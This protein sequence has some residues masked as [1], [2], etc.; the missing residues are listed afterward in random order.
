MAG[1]WREGADLL[2]LFVPGPLTGAVAVPTT[3]YLGLALLLL[4]GLGAF[5]LGRAGGRPAPWLLGAAA[6]AAL[7]LGPFLVVAGQTTGWPTPAGLLE[8]LPVLDRV[9]RWYRAG[10]VA[11]LLLAP[12][13]AWASPHRAA[14]WALAALVLVDGRLL[15]PLPARLPVTLLQ[16]DN[17]LVGLSGP[18]AELPPQQ[19]LGRAGRTADLNLLLQLAHG[20]PT[21]GTLD[22]LPGAATGPGLRD[23]QR[24]LRLPVSPQGASL[25]AGGASQL[26]RDGYRWLA[27]YPGLEGGGRANLDA[28]LGPPV[29]EDGGIAV[30]SLSGPR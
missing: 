24:A 18:I 27:L 17:V 10:A 25:A 21:T 4:A 19:P 11:L 20:Q 16:E 30:Y 7:S 1:A 29:R 3:A 12:L 14:A 28:A 15:G 5:R 26:A 23:L 8:S 13:A 9:T 2:D 22:S 6:F